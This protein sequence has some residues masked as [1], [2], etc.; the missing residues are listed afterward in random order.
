MLLYSWNI[1]KGHNQNILPKENLEKL[2]KHFTT[3]FGVLKDITKVK[4]HHQR[5]K[6]LEIILENLLLYLVKNRDIICEGE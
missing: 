3:I 4:R 6:K 1:D 5:G 2:L